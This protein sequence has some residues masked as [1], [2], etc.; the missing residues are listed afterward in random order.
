M[1]QFIKYHAPP[2]LLMIVIF[3]FSSLP[4]QTVQISTNYWQE[5]L[6]KKTIHL[7]EYGTLWVLLYRSFRQKISLKKASKYSLIIAILFAMSDEYHQTFTPN[8]TG[9]VRD[10]FID[11]G[12]ILIAQY[13]ILSLKLP[14]FAQKLLVKLDIH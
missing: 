7:I 9:T 12:G 10:V 5:F 1:K 2:L 8:R 6:I 4:G 11:I 14:T 3:Y 13:S